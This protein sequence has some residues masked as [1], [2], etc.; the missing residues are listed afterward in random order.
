M[1]IFDLRD[2]SWRYITTPKLGSRNFFKRVSA[3]EQC[4]WA[5]SA[6]QQPYLFVH[7]TELP[8]RVKVETYENQRWGIL[9]K[10]SH[11][12]MFPSDR[13]QFSSKD[14]KRS[15]PK[16]SFK[17]PSV[18]W[19]W[20]GD[21]YIDRGLD[22]DSDGWQYALDFPRT[23]HPQ[24]STTSCVRR[25]LWSRYYRFDGY[26]RWIKVPGLSED[27][28]KDPLQDIAVGGAVIPGRDPGYLAVWAVTFQGKVIYRSGVSDKCPEGEK[29]IEVPSPQISITQLSV[30]P[31]GVV[32]GVTWE[33][34]AVVRVGVSFYE[35]TGT[36]WQKVASP[37]AAPELE[38]CRLLQVSAGLSCLWA[39]TKD[40]QVWFRK[41]LSRASDSETTVTGSRWVQ[42][43]GKFSLITVGLN[44]QVFAL[45]TLGDHIYF[46]T[47]VTSDE[48][49]GRTWKVVHMNK[50]LISCSEATS[51]DTVSSD[52]SSSD[53]SSSA[54]NSESVST[55]SDDSFSLANP[56]N[57][58]SNIEFLTWLSSGA[59]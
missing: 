37:D 11:K 25:R 28:G 19:I 31:S 7:A 2:K 30:S 47:D 20:E 55:E 27:P 53:G 48:L 43:V 40:G 58:P 41:G 34:V 46:R 57:L 49:V 26:D 38:P 36:A 5:I 56:S 44:D 6:S 32:W 39:L 54:E 15:L 17:L 21:W 16:E 8:I 35:P 18:E 42:M 22:G 3:V 59:C 23:Y 51:L 50:P 52:G 10:W 24:Q 9:N 12:S 14:G 45:S 29:W 13:W 4:A 33:G 1:F